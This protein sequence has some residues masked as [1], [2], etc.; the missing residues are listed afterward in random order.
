MPKAK[1]VEASKSVQFLVR[2]PSSMRSWLEK[3]AN[4]N[5]RSIN[6]EILAR[7]EKS[8]KDESAFR[9]LQTIV[10]ELWDRVEQLERDSHS[11]GDP[12]AR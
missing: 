4:E 6:S 9:E 11:H 12:N 1:N 10:E 2:L 8:K 5:G 7:L 3:V